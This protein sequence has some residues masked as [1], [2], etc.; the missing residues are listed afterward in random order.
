MKRGRRER[1]KRIS[2]EKMISNFKKTKTQK[3]LLNITL[4]ISFII[5]SSIL[6]FYLSA[7]ST[8]Y[9]KLLVNTLHDKNITLSIHDT[10]DFKA[11]KLKSY[12]EKKNYKT[13]DHYLLPHDE[14]KLNNNIFINTMKDK[15]KLSTM[16]KIVFN[17]HSYN[18]DAKNF[19][20]FNDEQ[21]TFISTIDDK[22]IKDF[23]FSLIK[24]N[25]PTKEDEVLVTKFV[26][27]AYKEAGYKK[28]SIEK[29]IEKEEDLIGQTLTINLDKDF[30]KEN[31]KELKI[32]GIIDTKID[33]SHYNKVFKDLDYINDKTISYFRKSYVKNLALKNLFFSK[34]FIEKNKETLFYE[35]TNI[36]IDRNNK[37]KLTTLMND[38][39]NFDKKSKF[40]FNSLYLNEHMITYMTY[41]VSNEEEIIRSTSFSAI[42]FLIALCIILSSSFNYD[43]KFYV[44]NS[45][46]IKNVVIRNILY[47]LIAFVVGIVANVI[48]QSKVNK[49]F[50]RIT[51]IE[52]ILQIDG[53]IF[54]MPLLSAIIVSFFIWLTTLA[55]VLLRK[56][57]LKKMTNK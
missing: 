33:L 5:A 23:N 25:L 8:N 6:S 13:F 42:A 35:N 1:N 29:N 44:K 3:I 10:G 51:Q 39:K 53:N 28:D 55:I 18:G 54:G 47:I 31:K 14:K 36:S 26:F 30:N 40:N 24:G 32:V 27:D 19:I 41:A 2:K 21:E 17:I 22:K 45:K 34:D 20:S 12:L 46:H 4:F 15:S 52:N 16:N 38:I 43:L 7:F 37:E 50:E 48:L 9:N 57:N 49:M 56:N 11:D